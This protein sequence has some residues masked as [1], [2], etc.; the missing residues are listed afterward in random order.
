MAEL[1]LSVPAFALATLCYSFAIR[2]VDAWSYAIQALVNLGRVKLA[3]S[4]GLQLPKTFEE[5]KHMWGL[6]AGYVYFAIPEYGQRLDAYRKAPTGQRA[7]KR[8]EEEVE[9][10]GTGAEE[11]VENSGTGVDDDMA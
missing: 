10:G 5:E 3:D 6:F 8:A 4:L 9:N 1:L 7:E 2:A 11:E